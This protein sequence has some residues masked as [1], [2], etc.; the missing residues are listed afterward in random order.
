MQQTRFLPL[1]I[2][3]QSIRQSHLMLGSLMFISLLLRLPSLRLG[4]WR[5][6]ASTYFDALPKNL[7]EII[8]TVIYSELNPP[9][10]YLIM[11]QWMHW[12]GVN[13]VTFKLP[14][15][16]F[17]LLLIPATYAL[18][19][20][21]NSR[22]VG[23]IA[24]AITTF[25]PE[26]IY[27]SQEARPYTLAAL[28]CCLVVLLYCKAIASNQPRWYLVGLI[29]CADLLIYV[30]YTGL[31]LI[32]SLAIITLYL[33][34][35]P[36]VNIRLMP[37][38]IAFG[39]IFLLFTPWLPVFLTHLHTGLPW[40]TKAPWFLRPKILV[41]N[42]MYTFPII[43]WKKLLLPLILLALIVQLIHLF[44]RGKQFS[45]QQN[46]GIKTYTL[47]LNFSF[48]VS[49]TALA[50]LS[51]TGRYMF[52]FAPIAWVVYAN[53][54]IILLQY[55]DHYWSSR[56]NQLARQIVVIL[57]V[58]LLVFS[59]FLPNTKY[60]LSL[61]NIDKS[62][63]RS[64]AADIQKNYHEKTIYLIDPDYLAPTFGYYFAKHPVEF[65]GV[66]RWN[67]P[68]IFSP[69]GYAE[70]WSKPTLMSDIEQ[71]IEDKIHKGY[72]QLAVIRQSGTMHDFGKMKYSLL[73]GLLS[74]LKQTYPL[75]EQ[76]NYPGTIEPITLYKFALS[77]RK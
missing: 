28:L 74:K 2:N 71:H 5:D 10:F 16:I 27:Y 51:D 26:A 67:H 21:I 66:G 65:Y 40:A 11:H 38:A 22:R 23:V 42:I 20:L 64:L 29:I 33:R 59:L 54:F 46:I 4:L 70:V 47:I 24:A 76:T 62:G 8:N 55:I 77:S 1:T 72:R 17:G 61:G 35:Y 39:I 6:E 30:Q 7:P 49:A 57:L 69:Q 45:T 41:E 68:E 12:F 37:F 44:S 13:D 52:P 9:G 32:I 19:C 31:L 15:F 25:A 63:I 73:E 53:S 75:L 56:R 36:G 43:K 60:A 50:A 14:A 18:G 48:L 34:W 3:I 58:V